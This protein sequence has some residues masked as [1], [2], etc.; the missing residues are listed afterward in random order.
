MQTG[1]NFKP[2]MVNQYETTI[3]SY[4]QF[5]RYKINY[6]LAFHFISLFKSLASFDAMWGFGIFLG[7]INPSWSIRDAGSEGDFLA[8]PEDVEGI[9]AVWHVRVAFLNET[10]LSSWMTT[11]ENEKNLFKKN[12]FSFQEI[13]KYYKFQLKVY[14][15]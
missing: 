9:I 3:S 15:A 1:G 10:T 12:Q 5:K 7:I 14:W 13:W 6:V 8:T 4:F 11:S 2:K